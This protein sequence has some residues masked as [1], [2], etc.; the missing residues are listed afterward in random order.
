MKEKAIV[1]VP[2]Y[3]EAKN[4]KR[5]LDEIL[6]L[7][8]NQ[9]DILVVDDNSPDNTADVV[10]SFMIQNPNVFLLTRPRKS[11]LGTAYVDGFKFALSKNYELIL[12]M[13]ADFSHNPKDLKRLI[14]KSKNADVVIGSRYIN[15]VRVLNWPIK[16]LFL[17]VYANLYAKLITGLPISDTTGGFKCFRKQVLES[18][19]LG[20]I[21]SN[22]YA[23]QIELNFKAYKKG[24][25]LVE[26][27][28]VFNDRTE[29]SSKMNKKIVFEAAWKVWY[30]R[31][32][33]ILGLLD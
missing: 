12:Q 6:K 26:I 28:I 22:G 17:S 14:K 30:L 15:G 16:R 1:I 32:Q 29:G 4:I 25:K 31:L 10:R 8:G 13:D 5:L 9:L 33:S 24:F 19:N 2:T 23:F 20:S 21:K 27:P 11:G 7:Y 3:N 18:I